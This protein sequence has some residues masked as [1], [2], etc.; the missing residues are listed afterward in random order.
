M[1]CNQPCFLIFTIVTA[2]AKGSRP[3]F[4]SKQL[5]LYCTVAGWSFVQFQP[6]LTLSFLNH[7]GGFHLSK[8]LH[9]GSSSMSLLSLLTPI[10]QVS[11]AASLHPYPF[12]SVCVC[13]HSMV[14]L[15]LLTL[16]DSSTYTS[17]CAYEDTTRE[18]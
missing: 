15:S 7:V 11:L 8:R 13:S 10:I 17:G 3:V 16:L 9:P 18:V 14:N 2:S 4:C 12:P 1:S 6:V 5:I